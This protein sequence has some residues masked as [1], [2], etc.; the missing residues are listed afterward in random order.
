MDH[1]A[2]ISVDP[3]APRLQDELIPI[4]LDKQDLPEFKEES[5]D[6]V[7]ISIGSSE[8]NLSALAA[9]ECDRNE[10]SAY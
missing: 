1:S 2:N 8:V 9:D 5:M 6:T 7:N 10:V 3:F 4:E